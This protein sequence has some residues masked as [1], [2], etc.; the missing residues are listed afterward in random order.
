MCH[1]QNDLLSPNSHSSDIE[2]GGG[3]GGG[4][5]GS[6]SKNCLAPMPNTGSWGVERVG[7]APPD[8]LSV[9]LLCALS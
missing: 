4:H 5:Q 8:W 6:L 3:G 9:V 2:E 7:M 1:T